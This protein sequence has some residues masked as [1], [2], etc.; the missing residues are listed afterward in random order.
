MIDTDPTDTT[1]EASNSDT[2]VAFLGG[3][4]ETES[5]AYFT[6]FHEPIEVEIVKR[7]PPEQSM[8]DIGHVLIDHPEWERPRVAL[9]ENIQAKIRRIK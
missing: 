6:G 1:S 8:N 3:E 2:P 7:V 4:I 5:K 9:P